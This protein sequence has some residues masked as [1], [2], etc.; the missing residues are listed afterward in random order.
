MASS[1]YQKDA[2]FWVLVWLRRFRYV[3]NH[4]D[5]AEGKAKPLFGSHFLELIFPQIHF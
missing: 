5:Q 2:I 1:L 3:T 4:N